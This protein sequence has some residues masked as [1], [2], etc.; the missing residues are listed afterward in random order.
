[1]SPTNGATLRRRGPRF[2]TRQRPSKYKNRRETVDGITFDSVREA[3]RFQQLRLEERAG[4]IHT[5]ERQVPF[6]ITAIS[7]AGDRKAVAKYIADFTYY[8]HQPDGDT[9]YVVEDV[10]GVQTDVFR[11]KRKLVEH[12]HGIEIQLT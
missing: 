2:G 3:R 4:L 10:K 5:L 1:M 11:L 9:L 7:A 8:R 12:E 6:S